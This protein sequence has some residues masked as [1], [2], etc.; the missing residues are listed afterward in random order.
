MSIH[1]TGPVWRTQ[2]GSATAKL[3]MLVL[4]DYSDADGRSCWPSVGTIAK[5]AELNRATVFRALDKLKEDGWI[6]VAQSSN[7]HF[8][9]CW[10]I[11]LGRILEACEPTPA[12]KTWPKQ[13]HSETPPEALL[14]HSAT[15]SLLNGVQGSHATTQG[16][17][18]ATRSVIGDPPQE[19]TSTTYSST[20]STRPMPPVVENLD[21]ESWRDPQWGKPERLVAKYNKLCPSGHPH[22]TTLSPAR[23]AKALAY[24]K[25][26]PDERF[27]NQAF[28]AIKFSKFLMR[29]SPDRPNFRGTFD[30]LL[31]RGR[32]GTE[33]VV[34]TA[35]G[36]YADKDS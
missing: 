3:V 16:S 6:R 35:E 30:W 14:S 17:H 5:R 27:W 18:C 2:F 29:G 31:T 21:T 25:A 11:N 36:R 28:S 12:P 20:A 10:E 22:V 13:S 26:F 7:G 32:D 24:L 4:A 1:V 33:N 9:T 23:K 19:K 8:P 34:K 15:P